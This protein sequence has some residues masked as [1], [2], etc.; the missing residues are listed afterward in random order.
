MQSYKHER[1]L[2]DALLLDYYHNAMHLYRQLY[3]KNLHYTKP[4]EVDRARPSMARLRIASRTILDQPGIFKWKGRSTTY[5]CD[6][7]FM[8]QAYFYSYC[9]MNNWTVCKALPSLYVSPFWV[10]HRRHLFHPQNLFNSRGSRTWSTPEWPQD[11]TALNELRNKI[12][13]KRTL[14]L[15]LLLFFFLF[16][17]LFFLLLL[18]L[19][20]LLLSLLLLLWQEQWH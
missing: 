14:L 17:F 11:L 13:Y 19:L 6:H 12:Q 8:I 16:F 4:P 1:N 9:D 7:T 15:L 20:L 5:Q 18:L 10:H 2:I 3:D